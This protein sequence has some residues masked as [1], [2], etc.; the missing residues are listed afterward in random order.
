MIGILG[1]TFDPVHFGHL[2]PA[3]EIR[4]ALGLAEIRLVPCHVPPHRAAP[5]ATPEQRVQMLEA[6]IAGH[7]G[8]VIDRRE[9]ERPGP[10]YMLDTLV[11]LRGDAGSGGQCLLVGMDVLPGLPAW[12]RWRELLDHCHMVVMIRPGAELP[13]RGEL[14]EHVRRHRVED[15]RAL[16]E[17][18]AGCL[19]FQPVSQLDIS[20]TGIRALLARGED[21]GFLLP[22]SVLA[23]IRANHMYTT[24]RAP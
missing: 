10:S 23:Y 17:Q 8:F 18:P 16:R 3:L 4:Q 24:E 9:L 5:Q 7:E 21:A 15:A 14:G 13:E 12:H 2:R 11:S 6:A 1:G 19:L 22:D 20:A